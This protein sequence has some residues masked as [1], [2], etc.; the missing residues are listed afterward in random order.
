MVQK[1]FCWE[2][3]TAGVI[4]GWYGIVRSI[5]HIVS[6]AI[7]LANFEAYFNSEMF[8]S[9]FEIRQVFI[10]L[11]G[12]NV[13]L[14]I[15][16]LFACGM[17]IAGTTK[18]NRLLLIPWL[19]SRTFH[20]IFLIIVIITLIVMVVVRVKYYAVIIAAIVLFYILTGL[21]FYSWIAIYSLYKQF[22]QSES[23]NEYSR[24]INDRTVPQPSYTSTCV[25][26]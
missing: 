16:H 7:M 20:L 5:A 17:L 11:F 14:S 1:F 6:F 2:L 8:L 15:I 22:C 12:I 13:A 24:L 26:E 9:P 25:K 10:I 3:H 23:P 19:I 4:I 18:K 21:Y